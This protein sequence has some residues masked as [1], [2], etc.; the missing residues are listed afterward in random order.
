MASITT[1]RL[2]YFGFA[3]DPFEYLDST[4]DSHLQEYLVIPKAAE[5]A[6]SDQPVAIFAQP[7]GGKSALRIYTANF[8]NDSR[9]VKFPITYVPETYSVEPNFHFMGIKRSLARAVFMY[10]VSY[11]DLFFVLSTKQRQAIKSVLIDLPFGLD[12]NLRVLAESHFVSDLEQALGTSSLSGIPRLDRTHQ[13][14]ARELERESFPAISLVLEECFKSLNDAF[15][16]KSIHILV[17]GLDGFVETRLSHTWINWIEPLLKVI[18]KWEK[19]NIYLKLFLPIDISDVPVMVNLTDLRAVA[20]AW[21]NNLLAEIIRRRVFVASRGNFDSLDAISTPDLRDI[22]LTLV[23][24]LGLKEKLP[25]QIILKNRRLLQSIINTN[26]ELIS[27]DDL[28]FAG[29]PS[30]VAIV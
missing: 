6:L 17:D 20:L 9:G 3:F 4:N 28:I 8:Y 27:R 1:K 19:E 16:T 10:L 14:L 12:F 29:E 11:P 13:Q 25:R 18:D 30:Y 15:G 7:G 23:H 22:E 21:D 2:T 5:V 26:K 24:Q